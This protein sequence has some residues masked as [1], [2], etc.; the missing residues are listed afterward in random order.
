MRE[1]KSLDLSV[2]HLD[3]KIPLS[4]AGL[5]ALSLL[6]VSY[7]H[8]TGTIP[9]GHQLQTFNE[10]SFIGNHALCRDPLPGCRKK[11]DDTKGANDD[12]GEPDGTDWILVICMIVGLDVGFWITIGT[13]I[14]S[15]QCRDAYYHFLDEMRINA[16]FILL[17]S[18]YISHIP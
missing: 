11:T 12:H 10:F 15:K 13:L 3:G 17:V 6:N 4:L 18:M 14:V 9:T 7:N 8:V 1:L 2:N 16:N 5:T